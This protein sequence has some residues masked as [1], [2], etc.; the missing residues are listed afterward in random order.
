MSRDKKLSSRVLAEQT[1]LSRVLGDAKK[2]SGI[3]NAM[4]DVTKILDQQKAERA[5]LAN[6]DTSAELV[7]HHQ[8]AF[9]SVATTKTVQ[10]IREQFQKSVEISYKSDS[11]DRIVG[12]LNTTV[13]AATGVKAVERALVQRSAA[14]KV[15]SLHA[16][17]KSLSQTL[18]GVTLPTIQTIEAEIAKDISITLNQLQNSIAERAKLYA[19]TTRLEF[20]TRA[21]KARLNFSIAESTVMAGE[22]TGPGRRAKKVRDFS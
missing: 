15:A 2:A 6:L 20:A 12:Q 13:L 11:L 10:R 7:A 4:R 16:L 22:Q 18:N 5:A 1:S 17:E 21:A 3:A 14:M 9:E 8:R 19:D